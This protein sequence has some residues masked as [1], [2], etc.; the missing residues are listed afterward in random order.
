MHDTGTV[1]WSARLL[2]KRERGGRDNHVCVCDPTKATTITWSRPLCLK[3]EIQSKAKLAGET[4]EWVAQQCC[5]ETRHVSLGQIKRPLH[6]TPD[7]STSTATKSIGSDGGR[8]TVVREAELFARRRVDRRVL[9]VCETYTKCV[10][11]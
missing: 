2:L 8:V 3:L 10:H 9:N 1:A 7:R 4:L 11:E 5:G 6:Q